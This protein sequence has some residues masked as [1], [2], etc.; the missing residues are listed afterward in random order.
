MR[1]RKRGQDWYAC[2]RLTKCPAGHPSRRAPRP[3]RPH[4]DRELPGT[5]RSPPLSSARPLDADREASVYRSGQRSDTEPARK[6][7]ESALRGHSAPLRRKRLLTAGFHWVTRGQISVPRL[8]KAP[9]RPGFLYAGEE[10]HEASDPNEG[11]RRQHVALGGD[12][13][14]D[15]TSQIANHKS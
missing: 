8:E 13:V 5:S 7:P 11:Q 14:S 6:G 1:T 4:W 9:L 10:Q 12:A 3:G 15:I 2:A